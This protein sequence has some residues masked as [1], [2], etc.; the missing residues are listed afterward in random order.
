MNAPF[1]APA[2][3]GEPLLSVENLDLHFTNRKGMFRRPPPPTRA[4]DGVSLTIQPGETLSLVGESGSG[5]TTLGRCILGVHRATAGRIVYQGGAGPV[6]LTTLSEPE[7]K[8]Y[9]REIRMIFQ[10]PNSSLNPRR[11]VI[12]LIGECLEIHGVAKGRERQQRVA[13]LL[14][15]VGLRPEYMSRYPHAFSG[16]ER[17]R[18]GIARAL[19]LDPRLVVCDEAVSALDVSVQA[20][21][22]NLLQDLQAQR[23]LTYLFIAHDLAVVEHISDRIA[24]MY[25]SRLVEVAKTEALFSQ[26]LHPY[27]EALIG[28]IPLPDPRLRKAAR[29]RLGGEIASLSN[30]P[31]GCNFHPRCRYATAACK[32]ERPPLRQLADRQVA[33]HHA[34][35]LVLKGA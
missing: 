26:P 5:K 16:G 28:T 24:V 10:D 12:D 15:Q 22:I 33:C 6:E 13:E 9:R 21:I 7:L 2:V 17:Q 4:V 23:G 29:T 31:P 8:P 11:P 30:P 20:Q 14:T 34:E 27:T 3:T 25:A 19:A 1:P 35:Q 18:I 32:L